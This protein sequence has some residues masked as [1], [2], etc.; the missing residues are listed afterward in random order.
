MQ[1]PLILHLGLQ[2]AGVTLPCLGNH[3]CNSKKNILSNSSL[4]LH[5]VQ[6]ADSAQL[7]VYNAIPPFTGRS[8]LRYLNPL[9]VR[10]CRY[11][12]FFI[13]Y[14]EW[15][16]GYEISSWNSTNHVLG[17][18]LI[19]SEKKNRLEGIH[20]PPWIPSSGASPSWGGFPVLIWIVKKNIV[21]PKFTRATSQYSWFELHNKACTTTSARQIVRMDHF[22]HQYTI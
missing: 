18:I 6:Y 10:I 17:I 3:I 8:T 9:F 12:F 13:V 22:K 5:T 14:G 11:N 21:I 19:R 16:Y 1:Y 15:T 2:P 4:K 7:H 20:I